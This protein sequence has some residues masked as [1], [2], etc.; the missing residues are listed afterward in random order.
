M[1]KYAEGLKEANED[2][3][4]I[5]NVNVTAGQEGNPGARRRQEKDKPPSRLL[6]IK[7]WHVIV[8]HLDE[9]HCMNAV[10][11]DVAIHGQGTGKPTH[12]SALRCADL[13]YH[14]MQ[15]CAS[16]Q[17]TLTSVVATWFFIFC[18]VAPPLCRNDQLARNR[19]VACLHTTLLHSRTC[20]DSTLCTLLAVASPRPNCSQLHCAQL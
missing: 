5:I 1:C 9:L 6:P 7:G 16:R 18:D 2:A 20:A 3:E 19:R 8:H 4:E 11:G 13:R 12:M 17:A 10:N 14:V 15:V